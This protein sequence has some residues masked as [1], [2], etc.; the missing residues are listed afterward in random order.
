M[1]IQNFSM[2]AGNSKTITATLDGIPTLTGAAIQFRVIRNNVFVLVKNDITVSGTTMTITLT[3]TDT[4]NLSGDYEYDIVLTD[5]NGNVTTLFEGTFSFSKGK[6]G[7][8]AEQVFTT[9]MNLMDEESEDGTFTGY[10]QEYKRKSWSILTMLQAELTPDSMTPSMVTDETS[11]F[12]LDNWTCLSVLP[13]GLAAH[14]LLTD[15]PNRASFFNSRYDELKQKIPS[16]I[17]AIQNVYSMDSYGT[18]T[19]FTSEPTTVASEPTTSPADTH[20]IADGGE[21]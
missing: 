20:V 5:A 2:V 8:T 9:A 17:V 6:G 13:Y 21:F 1:T 3:P 18:D 7:L 16:S 15:D 10:P 12:Y 19:I 11:V 14:L 4:Q